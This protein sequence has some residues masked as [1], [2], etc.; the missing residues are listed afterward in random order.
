MKVLVTGGAGFVGSHVVDLL[1]ADGAEVR[2]V[3]RRPG[4]LDERVELLAGDLAD[5]AVA[6][7]AVADVDAVSHQASKVG[8]GVDFGD[9]S[10]YVEDNDLGTARLLEALWRRSFRGRL[11]LASSMVVYGEGRYRC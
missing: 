5:P 10:G 8:L 3:D 11:V 6:E 9:V 7:A 1:L 2:V 4:H